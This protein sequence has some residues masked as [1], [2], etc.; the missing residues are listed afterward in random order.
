MPRFKKS[1]SHAMA[2]LL[3]DVTIEVV[4]TEDAEMPEGTEDTDVA[5]GA[6]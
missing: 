6:A 3:T 5:K 4:R 2:A 1:Q